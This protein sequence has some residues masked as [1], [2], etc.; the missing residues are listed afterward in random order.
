[1]KRWLPWLFIVPTVLTLLALGSWQL[2]RLQW[3]ETVMQQYEEGRVKPVLSIN[4]LSTEEI[5]NLPYRRVTI[6]GEFHHDKEIHL[7]GRRRLGKTGYHLLT[8]MTLED[9]RH[10]LVNRGW[11][12]FKKKEIK[13]RPETVEQEAAIDLQGVIRF[14]KPPNLITP[15][16]HPEKN[17]WFSVDY[18]ALESFTELKL[19]PVV[20]EL[21]NDEPDL[22]VLP[23]VSDGKRVFRNDHLGYAITWFSL[24]IAA[25]VIFWARIL[26][27]E[28]NS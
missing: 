24:A 5:Q 1:M 16:N 9:G 13:D 17:F 4:S 25:M 14:P 8:P 2:Q 18:P 7:G 27:K 3:K 10:F 21:M 28:S 23:I 12:P 26:R 22:K 20:I 15:S 6:S 19:E 11:I